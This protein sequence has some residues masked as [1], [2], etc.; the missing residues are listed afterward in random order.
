MKKFFM[1][2]AA[3]LLA[4]VCMASS[5]SCAEGGKDTREEVSYTV[6]RQEFT[7]VPVIP[8]SKDGKEEWKYVFSNPGSGWYNKSFNDASWTVGVGSFGSR[9]QD[10]TAWTTT[11]IWLR[12][13]FT[14]DAYAASVLDSLVLYVSHDED[15]QIYINGVV[16]AELGGY[17][18][19][20]YVSISDKAKASIKVGEKNVMAVH[21]YNGGAPGNIDVGIYKHTF[22]TSVSF[23][24]TAEV[25][26]ATWK[27]VTE[28]PASEEWMNPAFDDAAWGEGQAGFGKSRPNVGTA[29]TTSDIWLRKTVEIKGLAAEDLKA[30]KFYVECDG[31]FEV[32][33]NGFEAS[34]YDLSGSLKMEGH[35]AIPA[36]ALQLAAESHELTIAAH[37]NR[38]RTAKFFDAAL[39]A[40]LDKILSAKP[41][42]MKKGSLTSVFAEDIDVNNVWGEYPRP[43]MVREE[44][45]SLNG[46]WELQPLFSNKSGMP[47]SDAYSMEI[48]VPFPVESPIS[49]IMQHYDRFAYRRTFTV[50]A[51]WK[52][53]NLLLHF[54]AVDWECEV[55]VNGKRVGIHKGGYDNFAFDVTNYLVDGDE[56]E[57]VVKVYDPTD[58]GGQPRGKQTLSPGGIMY[59]STSGIWQSVWMEPVKNVHIEKYTVVPNI[60]NSTVT[61]NVVT[62]GGKTVKAVIAVKDGDKV[63]AKVEA[64]TNKNVTIT[65]PNAKW[66]SPDSPFLYDLDI[67][68]VEGGKTVDAVEGYFGMRKISLGK[69]GSHTRMFLNNEPLFHIGPLD[70]GFWPDGIYTAPTDEALLY[71]I[72]ITKQMGFNMIRKHIKVEPRRWYYH[73]DRLGMLVWQDMPS[74]ASYG[75]VGIDKTH[76]KKELTA[77]IENLYNSP[78][79]IMWIIFNESQGR[80]DVET[81]VNHVRSLD[82]SRL[83]NLDSQYGTHSTYIGDVWDV[84]HYPNPAFI[85][86]PNKNLANVCGEYGGLKYKE[87]GHT[88]GSGDWGYATMNSRQELLDTYGMYVDDLIRFRDF[89]GMGGAV[90]TQITDVEI[91]IN[92][93]VTY[94]RAVVKVDVDK[95]AEYNN[96]LFDTNNRYKTDVIIANAMEGGENWKMTTTKPAD[97]WY[98]ANFDDSSWK[99]KKSGFGTSNTPNAVVGTVWDTEDIWIRKKFRLDG[100]DRAMADSLIMLMTHDEDCEIYINDKLLASYT[101]YNNNYSVV[102]FTKT[103]KDALVYDADNTIAVHCHQ[104]HGGQFIDLGIYLLSKRGLSTSIDDVVAE[105]TPYVTVDKENKAV[106]I[107][108]GG[109]GEG[110]RVDVINASGAHVTSVASANNSVALSS[111]PS[112]VYLLRFADGNKIHAC[113][114]VL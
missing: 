114:V 47:A 111:L 69:D 9:S 39:T 88:W 31:E 43:Q 95:M 110:T 58:M 98:T 7:Y 96:R 15:C 80:H 46:I 83:V 79:I 70:Q 37:V 22:V 52:G 17:A 63:V 92:G 103:V 71:D 8:T 18:D 97:D 74:G 109:F 16:A 77:M 105:D 36:E 93:L 106:T 1:S 57:L 82:G 50:P 73:C 29:W 25:E 91:E 81:L 2:C 34:S 14:L 54:E 21:C 53:R 85:S 35:V 42:E 56:Q 19:Y 12:K 61:V 67:A 76:F 90:Y 86:C 55:Y 27:Y 32:Y 108:G 23:F 3:L 89:F 49:G 51:D 101:G 84:H 72:Q 28:T 107:I 33:F 10:N 60:D 113:E 20:K 41:W 112:G 59:T 24:K 62:A 65:V 5:I 30:L 45:Q 13:E 48:L 99:E 66:W 64:N 75:G 26:P 68:L 6:D 40:D 100:M 11:D 104:T 87:S 78:S 94:D 4:V 102:E 38:T 44:W